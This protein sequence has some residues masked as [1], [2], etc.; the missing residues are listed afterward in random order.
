VTKWKE[1]AAPLLQPLLAVLIGLLGGAVF[2]WLSGGSTGA[3]F[4]EMWKGAFGSF[5][6]TTATLT[7]ATPII[8]IGLGAA[9]AFR[10]GFFNMGFEGQMILGG[11]AAALTALYIPGPGIVKLVSA[12]VAGI[13][14][15]G[16][17]S[18]LAGWLDAKFRMNLIITTL[19][20]NYIAALFAGYLVAYPFKDKSGAG[21]MAQTKMIDHGAWLPK[22]FG[23]MT[24]HAGLVIA[25]VL[26]VALYVLLKYTV[27]GYGVRMLGDN[28]L[29]AGY[30]GIRRGRTMLLSMLASG[31]M[32]G[33]AGAAEVLGTQYRYIDGTFS[34]AGYAWS[35]IM[36][37]LLASSH[38]IGTAC[39]GVLL[40][41]LQTGAMGMERNTEVPIAISSVIQALLILFITA[42]LGF[43][44]RS[45]RSRRDAQDASV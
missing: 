39:A 36:A 32:A 21:A 13:A 3:A 44:L 1:A 30:G 29:F 35:G 28:S 41:A 12:L 22:L 40:A 18:A 7:R 25:I 14:A 2:I 16:V 8:L 38:P 37:A 11:V 27:W 23:G 19:L 15:G 20:M 45:R 31:A 34:A 4:A 43:R 42:K 6:Y 10:A 9:L 5:Y 26:A 24:V 33:L 17:W